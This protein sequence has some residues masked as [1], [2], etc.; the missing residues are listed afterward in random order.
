MSAVGS[1]AVVGGG[2]AGLGAAILLAEAG[3]TVDLVEATPDL[4]ALG[5]GITLQ[6]NA[7]RAL[8]RLGVWE[9]AEA[10]GYGFSSLGMRARTAPCS[11]RSPIP[12]ATAN[13]P[14][15]WAC[16]GPTWP[17]CSPNGP[18]RSA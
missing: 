7:L 14:L 17:A 9:R 1:V 3:V 5:S 16:T 6:H 8:A 4:T 15:R 13:C 11:P 2:V 12:G 10:L 18:S